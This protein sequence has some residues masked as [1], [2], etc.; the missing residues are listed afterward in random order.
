MTKQ[1]KPGSRAR[2]ELPA[3]LAQL[4][5]RG[6]TDHY[7]DPLLYD[8]E[9]R[10]QADDVEWYCALAEERAVGRTVLELGAGSGR[11]AIPLASEGHRVLALDRM[12]PMLA[13]LFT[14]LER[15][16]AAGEPVSGTVEPVLADMMD[17]PLDDASVGLVIAPF[18]CLMHLY[19]WRELLACFREVFRVLEPGGTFAFDV[20]LPDL[21]WLRWDPNERHAV[22]PFVHP[23]TGEAMIYST[24]HEYDPE[25]QICHIRIYYDRDEAGD[26]Q[27]KPGREPEQTVHLAHR[28]IYPDELRALLGIAGFELE[29][30]TGDFLDLS[31]SADIEVQAVICTKPR[32]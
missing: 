16:A 15:L 29:S 4:L 31:L 13:Q 18:N 12:E 30:Q 19:D 7:T 26:G 2:R 23:R 8:F 5:E 27:L 32:S 17:L 9:Y 20:L 25:T 28:Q 3:P 11:V 24:N 1:A 10:D 22:T 6:T 14:K 21:E